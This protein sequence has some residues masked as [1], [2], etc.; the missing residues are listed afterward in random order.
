MLFGN[1]EG[2]DV[3]FSGDS[4]ALPLLGDTIPSAGSPVLRRKLVR[5][6]SLVAIGEVGFCVWQLA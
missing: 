1:S 2:E 6:S 5:P 4:V 3:M